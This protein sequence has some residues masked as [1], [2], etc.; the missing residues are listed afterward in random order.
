MTSTQLTDIVKALMYMHEL[1]IVH[2]DLKG[3]GSCLMRPVAH[4]VTMYPQQSIFINQHGCACLADFGLSTVVGADTH[5]DPFGLNLLDANQGM[6]VIFG[7][8]CAWWA[9]PELLDWNYR[10]TKASDVYAL[11]MVIYEVRI[12]VS[13]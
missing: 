1:H 2:G 10:P 7:R 13:V 12:S 4:D 11:G 9:S 8:G 3:V 5:I 6:M